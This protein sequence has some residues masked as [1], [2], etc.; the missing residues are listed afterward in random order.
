MKSQH[1]NEDVTSTDRAGGTDGMFVQLGGT[2]YTAKTIKEFIKRC[3]FWG[4][5]SL[6]TRALSIGFQYVSM[7]FWLGNV[8]YM[9]PWALQMQWRHPRLSFDHLKW[10][11]P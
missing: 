7:R 5:G 2:S 1:A 8:T 10:N 6:N 11:A 4:E 3:H 9:I